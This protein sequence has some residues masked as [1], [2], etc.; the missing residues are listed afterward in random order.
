VSSCGGGGLKGFGGLSQSLLKF[1]SD[2]MQQIMNVMESTTQLSD[3]VRGGGWVIRTLITRSTN[4]TTNLFL[5]GLHGS[6]H[7]GAL[8]KRHLGRAVPCYSLVD[9]LVGWL[10]GEVSCGLR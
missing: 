3:K 7:A 5:V 2:Y 6:M 1:A 8:Q 9:Q 4:T 10:Q